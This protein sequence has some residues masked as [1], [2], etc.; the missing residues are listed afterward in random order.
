MNYEIPKALS[1]GM[2][3]NIDTNNLFEALSKM[4]CFA[5]SCTNCILGSSAKMTAIN[6]GVTSGSI[7]TTVIDRLVEQGIVTKAEGLDLML[8]RGVR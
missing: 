3:A 2:L 5:V 4:G 7:T 8:T 6:C 1:Y